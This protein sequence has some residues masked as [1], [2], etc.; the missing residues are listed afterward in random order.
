VSYSLTRYPEATVTSIDLD[1]SGLRRA[2]DRLNKIQ[3][4]R[5]RPIAGDVTNKPF[6][7]NQ[8]LITAERLFPHL[9]DAAAA[10]VLNKAAAVLAPGT[11]YRTAEQIHQLIPSSLEVVSMVQEGWKAILILKRKV[12]SS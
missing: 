5:F 4:A 1:G 3:R 10:K 6:P 2:N 8:S 11:F 9:D 7:N 12:T